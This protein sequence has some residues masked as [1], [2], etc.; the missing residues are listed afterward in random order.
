MKS[1]DLV[2]FWDSI[3]NDGY[4]VGL[5]IEIRQ[6][7]SR[8]PYDGRTREASVAY[9]DRVQNIP[10]DGIGTGYPLAEVIQEDVD[11]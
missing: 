3:G 8:V 10:A 6:I 9:K 5:V 1:G 2:R 7:L 4:V 11:V